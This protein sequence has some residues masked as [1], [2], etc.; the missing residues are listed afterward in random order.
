[1]VL[2]D[3]QRCHY[4]YHHLRMMLVYRIE[5]RETGIG[6]YHSSQTQPGLR[7]WNK[8]Y[9]MMPPPWMDGL[10]GVK[11]Y[12]RFAHPDLAV[13]QAHYR[14]RIL[15]WLH[16]KG[17]ILIIYNTYNGYRTGFSKKQ[18]MFNIKHAEKVDSISLLEVIQ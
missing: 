6:P 13:I 1:M 18:V 7:Q 12:H 10:H 14:K 4:H 11:K 5:H 15:K 8:E 16:K 3:R 17:Y 2:P 9:E